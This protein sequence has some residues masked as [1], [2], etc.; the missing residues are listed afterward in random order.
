MSSANTEFSVYQVAGIA[1]RISSIEVSDEM[2]TARAAQR[3]R[4]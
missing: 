2:I 1:V 3:P 4:K